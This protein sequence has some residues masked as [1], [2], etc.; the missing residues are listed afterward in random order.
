LYHIGAPILR[1]P[2]SSARVLAELLTGSGFINGAVYD[3]RGKIRKLP[4][5]KPSE[6]KTFWKETGRKIEPFL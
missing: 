4:E 6:E 1:R 3:V 5:I 2:A